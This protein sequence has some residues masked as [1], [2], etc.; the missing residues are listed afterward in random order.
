[1]HVATFYHQKEVARL[2]VDG[3][4]IDSTGTT[5]LHIACNEGFED[6]VEVLLRH[7]SSPNGLNS[8]GLSPINIA[9]QN[10]NEKIVTLLVEYGADLTVT[11][12]VGK[13]PIELYPKLKEMLNNTKGETQ[14]KPSGEGI[15]F[16]LRNVESSIELTVEKVD[17]EELEKNCQRNLACI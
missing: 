11:N 1:L 14:I 15:H 12:N 17:Q 16:A 9:V 4:K 10:K 2:L 3:F 8:D 6:I 13:N 5:A 7:H